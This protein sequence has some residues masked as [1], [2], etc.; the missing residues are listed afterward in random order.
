MKK[1][2]DP[3][4]SLT[5]KGRILRDYVLANPRKV[6]FMTTRELA[7]A[8]GVSE[9]TVV[10]FVVQVGF[11]GYGAFQQALR[12]LVDTQLTLVDR[13]DL[14][15]VGKPHAE[16]F[17]KV[18]FREIDNLKRLY[19]TMDVEKTRLAVE[20]LHAAASVFVVGSRL[21]YIMATY[22]SWSLQKIRR[23]IHSLRASDST[24]LDAL[25]TA[26]RR[27]LVL[28]VATSRYPNELIR[29]AKYARR[30]EHDLIVISDSALCPLNTF[31]D[32]A[33][34]SPS[35]N[36]SIFGCPAGILCLM[37]F[38]LLELAARYGDALKAHQEK[39]E[40]CYRENDLLFN[41]DA[42]RE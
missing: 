32:L 28:L 31:T 26:P 17:R 18:V 16:R 3:A 8:C 39:L 19:D 21:S 2:T 33:L 1:M 30:L 7:V 25:T 10:R 22:M 23:E 36:I 9:A 35:K 41:M 34:V 11:G 15:E 29:L 5:P 37:D 13:V 40:Q 42:I 38:L 12:D 20:R 6:V 27:S 4:V 14:M 24:S